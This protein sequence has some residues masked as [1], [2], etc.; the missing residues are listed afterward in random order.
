MAVANAPAAQLQQI[1]QAPSTIHI[2]GIGNV[3]VLN[4]PSQM[5]APAQVATQ[6]ALQQDPND[7]NKWHV[8]QV[9]TA[10]TPQINP[11]AQ[12]L[13]CGSTAMAVSSTD[14]QQN[15]VSNG[16]T[17]GVAAVASSATATA[18]ATT[19]AQ[20]ASASGQPQKTRLRRVA[21]TC[22]NCK[23]GDRTRS[24]YDHIQFNQIFIEI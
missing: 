21:C 18:A 8:V 9:A 1:A 2:P 23:D 20:G 14:Q 4:A 24:K 12:F 7:P 3:Q 19:T 5:I 22:P 17:N 15:I 10:Q 6:Q 16:Q 11:V 13:N